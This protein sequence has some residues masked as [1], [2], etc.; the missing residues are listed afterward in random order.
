MNETSMDPRA[1][2]RIIEDELALDGNPALNL[3]SFVT[4]YMDTEAEEL[5][6]QGMRK[7][8]IDLDEYHQT[9][10]LH[11]RC[12]AILANLFHA[13][14]QPGPAVGT[15][16]VGSSE[17]IMLAVLALKWKWKSWKQ[18]FGDKDISRPNLVFGSN[19]QGLIC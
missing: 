3:A 1:A 9:A 7:N 8:F 13:P 5:M 4:T 12:V 6:M 17:A 18:K 14:P 2:Q 16:C 10:E 11:N 19:V 15:G